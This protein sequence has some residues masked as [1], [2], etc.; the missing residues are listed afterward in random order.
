MGSFDG[1]TLDQLK[2]KLGQI[3]QGRATPNDAALVAQLQAAIKIKMDAAGPKAP[4]KRG[5]LLDNNNI[6]STQPGKQNPY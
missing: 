5:D 2:I 4:D 6:P 3:D 1:L